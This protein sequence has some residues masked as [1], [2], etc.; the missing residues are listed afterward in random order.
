MI[1]RA[2]LQPDPVVFYRSAGDIMAA[3][4]AASSP[5]DLFLRRGRWI[6]PGLLLLADEGDGQE[7]LFEI[8]AIARHAT[9]SLRDGLGLLDQVSLYREH[10][11]EL[12]HPPHEDVSRRW[13]LRLELPC[14]AGVF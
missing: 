8:D 9:G 5:D 2:A 13:K 3:G 12:W 11:G 10:A 14:R 6:E 7:A 4:A 1:N